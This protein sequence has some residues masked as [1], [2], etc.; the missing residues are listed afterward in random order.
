MI[1][2]GKQ[3]CGYLLARHPER[4]KTVF[5]AKKPEKELAQ[6]I[7]KAQKSPV[8]VEN[9]KAQALAKGGVHQ[10]IIMEIEP[11]HPKTACH[12][13]HYRALVVLVGVTDMGNIG[14]IIRTAYALGI[15][16]IVISGIK[17]LNLEGVIKSSSGAAFDLDILHMPSIYDFHHNL[18]QAGFMTIGATLEGS[19]Q[20]PESNEQKIALY[21]GSEGEGLPNR[22]IQK[23]DAQ[24]TI[25]MVREF[26]SLNVGHAAAILIDRM[27]YERN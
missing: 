4:V 8:R 27:M 12:L 5:L 2:Y 3:V 10:G 26:D 11:L 9:R 17:E 16:G 23:L 19:K 22:L 25:P 24:T 20:F 7:R 15:D 6:A 21:M 18:K 13:E 14:A 1:V